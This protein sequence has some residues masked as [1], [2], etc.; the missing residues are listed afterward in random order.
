M[1]RIDSTSAEADL[2]GEGKAGFRP[3]N[4]GLTGATAMTPDWCNAVQEEIARTV[5][6]AGF[7][8]IKGNNGQLLAAVKKLASEAA[9][10]QGEDIKTLLG[11]NNLF[12]PS[13]ANGQL[14]GDT[15][16]SADLNSF[17]TPGVYGVWN[18]R[19]TLN[20]IKGFWK[21]E[22]AQIGE[23]ILQ[24]CTSHFGELRQYIRRRR[25]GVWIEEQV[26]TTSALAAA[27]LEYM[28]SSA[29]EA[30]VKS[31]INVQ[32]GKVVGQIREFASET[33]AEVLRTVDGKLLWLRCDGRTFSATDYPALAVLYPG[34]KTPSGLDTGHWQYDTDGDGATYNYYHDGY[35][36]VRALP[37]A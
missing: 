1:H 36:F 3:G 28:Q 27:L 23:E 32:A 5:E 4:P 18:S 14:A 2:N 26:I 24:I 25:A 10:E 17:T 31:I 33:D 37:A 19:T 15:A 34:L 20:Q 16:Y 7:P 22:V 21:V 29:F 9:G 11:G 12:A 35:A 8:L 30:R 13:A 6:G